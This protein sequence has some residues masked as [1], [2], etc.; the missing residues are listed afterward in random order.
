MEKMLA[1]LIAQGI[2]PVMAECMIQS[3]KPK[4]EKA[5][6][7]GN[8]FF[9][10]KK[11]DLDVTVTTICECCGTKKVEVKTI[12]ALPDSPTEMKLPMS[13]CENCPD[14]FRAL[15][16]EQLVSLAVAAHNPTIRHTYQRTSS[17]VKLAKATTPEEMVFFTT[18]HY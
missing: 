4:K 8:G 9:V 6:K 7:K 2:D 17:V 11:V 5:P 18:K 16:H 15:T 12:Q 3:F 14:Y 13:C 1:A 10:S